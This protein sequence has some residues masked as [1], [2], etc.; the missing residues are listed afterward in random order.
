[1]RGACAGELFL[2]GADFSHLRFFEDRGVVYREGSTP[3]D[4]LAILTNRGINCVRL[5]LFTSSAAQA[6]AD[7]YNYINNLDYTLPLAV[8]V[9]NAGLRLLLD[10]HYSDT[11][12]DPGHQRVPAAWTN[13]TF[14]QL[15]GQV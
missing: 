1:M 2:A 5:R 15:V 6:A 9:K 10:F 11:W 8:R 4:A 7:P 14:A 3:R 13:L 12:A